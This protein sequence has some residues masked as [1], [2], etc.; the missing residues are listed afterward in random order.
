M[1]HCLASALARPSELLQA[2]LAG[3]AKEGEMAWEPAGH[4]RSFDFE[5]EVM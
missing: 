3:S 1:N 5:P 2:R 4:P